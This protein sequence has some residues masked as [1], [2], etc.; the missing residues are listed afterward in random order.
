MTSAAA[1]IAVSRF[2]LGP[3]PGELAAAGRDPIGWLKRQVTAS[4]PEFPAFADL[5]AGPERMGDLLRARQQRGD[6]GAAALFRQSFRDTFRQEASARLRTQI[7]STAP[8]RERLVAF[9]ANHFTVSVQR[10]PVLGLAGAFE[11]E[12]IRPHVFG[13][14]S[15]MLLAVARHPAMLV[16]LDNG[17]SIG[18]NSVVG[19]R[20]GRGLNENL[21]R[22][23]LELHTLGVEA[24]Y[25]QTDVR[26]FAKILTGWTMARAE[27]PGAGGF[28]FVPDIHEP[29][30]KML[31][32]RRFG[33][34]GE[35]DGREALLM[36][37]RHPAT[38]RHIATKLA[39]H[40]ITD[41]PPEAAVA[42]LTRL[43][44]DTGGNL[45][46]MTEAIIEQPEAWA[47][48]LPKIRTPHEFVVAALR[49]T[50][51]NGPG[52]TI[53]GSLR[54]LGQPSFAAPS[55]SGWP[56]TADRWIGPEAVLRRAEWSMALGLRIAAIRRP[57]QLFAETIAPVAGRT[58]ELAVARAPSAGEAMATLF[59]SPEFQRR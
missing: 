19:L 28:R 47:E 2:G 13:R 39:R 37:A 23:I 27:D 33:N 48:T 44:R 9:W 6:A 30:G 41:Q 7:E 3:R 34:G 40:F 5:P 49:A 52:E 1:V 35:S 32:G 36:L 18:P 53:L 24:G 57:D 54:T 20:R 43:F 58:T 21:A 56:D 45:A 51:F 50:E 38:A 10:P 11:R 59:A 4:A 55:P 12:A 8:L 42:R 16:Y 46:A 29:G 31:L 26:E 25:T 17:Q 15:D 14:F 22:E